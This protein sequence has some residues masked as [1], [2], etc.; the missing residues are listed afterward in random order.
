MTVTLWRIAADAPTYT[1]DDLSGTGAS[2]TGGRW[3]RVGVPLVYTSTSIALAALEVLAH[4][5]D[6]S[7]PLNRYL[8]CLTVP[9]PLWDSRTTVNAAALPIGWDASPAGMVSLDYLDAWR[10]GATSALYEIPSAIVPEEFNILINP[11]HPDASQIT[12]AK[13]RRWLFDP[14]VYFGP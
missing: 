9:K 5:N 3:N 10:S 2:I 8:V 1:A 14:R 4:R 12:A 7:L 11:V 13:T 6:A